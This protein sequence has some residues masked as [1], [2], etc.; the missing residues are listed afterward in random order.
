MK[1]K[2]KEIGIGVFVE[3]IFI[4]ILI[5]IYIKTYMLK[6]YSNYISNQMAWMGYFAI[7]IL[8]LMLILPIKNKRKI[9]YWLI[10]FIIMILAMVYSGDGKLSEAQLA[11]KRTNIGINISKKEEKK[12]KKEKRTIKEEYP[13]NGL[14]G[15]ANTKE[16][17]NNPNK[18]YIL[19]VKR[20]YISKD[21]ETGTWYISN[22]M[23][24][25]FEN[26]PSD[27][28]LE[29]YMKKYKLK[30]VGVMPTIAQYI[31]ELNEEKGFSKLLD[32][33][34][35]LKEDEKVQVV[36][37]VYATKEMVEDLETVQETEEESEE[38]QKRISEKYI[39]NGK[40]EVD[41][42]NFMQVMQLIYENPRTFEGIKIK[43]QGRTF[44]DPKMKENEIG[45]G[46]WQMFCCAIDMSLLGYLVQTNEEMQ[47]GKWYE[48]TAEIGINNEDETP[49]L[50]LESKKEIPEPE[51]TTI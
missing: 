35:T 1:N 44:K 30:K 23:V 38:K 45:I 9:G 10:P 29:Q 27:E 20:Q 43:L 36:D 51:Q 41:I 28:Y 46:Y 47:E 15:P 32:M 39:K 16:D 18:E 3:K 37:V 5:G 25:A 26:I 12:N 4:L 49:I 22:R 31:F 11:K 2:I 17:L 6:Q 50:K 21:E 7:V 24:V 8:V 40:V 13:M 33:I 19:P 14:E 42:D 48:I 34:Q